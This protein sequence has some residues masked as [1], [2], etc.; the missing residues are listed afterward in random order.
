[1]RSKTGLFLLMLKVL[2]LET[3]GKYQLRKPCQR[4]FCLERK[5]GLENMYPKGA[6]L[7]DINI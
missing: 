3:Q 7:F 4:Q 2:L 5:K 6:L 1:M